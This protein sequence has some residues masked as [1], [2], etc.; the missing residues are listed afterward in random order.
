MKQPTIALAMIVKGAKD[1]AEHLAN[2]LD[3]I[4]SSVDAIYL[5][6]NT[7]KGV[8]IAPEI[9]AVA[10]KYKTTY[11][12]T[13]WKGN[14]VEARNFIFDKVDKKYGFLMWLDADDTVDKPDEIR[15]VIAILAKTQQGVYIRYDYDHDEFGNTTVSHMVARI[16]RNNGSYTWQSSIADGGVAVHETLVEV[17]PRP[18]AICEDFKVIHHADSDRRTQSLIRNIGLLEGM[19][20]RQ[21]KSG[22]VDPRTLFYLATHYYDAGNYSQAKDLLQNYMLLSGWAEERC[23]ALIYL[24]KIME[25]EGKT[26]QA[27]HAYLLAIG[28]Y[29]NSPRP[30]IE[31]SAID[32]KR[33]RFEESA[34]WI[35][36]C[37]ALPPPSTT[38][39]Q[40]PMESTFKAYMLA[41]QAYV[42]I[43]GKKLDDA[44]KYVLK[45]LDLRPL[46]DEAQQSRD[47]IESMIAQ[48]EDIRAAMR[49]VRKFEENDTKK[50]LPFLDTLPA[51]VQDNPLILTTRHRYT[52]PKVWGDKTIALYVGQGPLGVW[53]PWSL[54]EGIGGSEEAVIRLSRELALLGWNVT[55]Y[56]TPGERWGTDVHYESA[57]IW[58]YIDSSIAEKPQLE[59]E[60][61]SK[62]PAVQWKQYYEFNPRDEYNVL[63][64]WRNPAFFDAEI[65]AKK[66][67][68]WLH[69]VM[70]KEE[71]LPERLERI[72]KVIFVGQYHADL[73][74]GIIPEEKWFVSGNGIEPKD[75]IEA[76]GKFKRVPHRMV[77]MSSH[78]RGLKIL[79]DNWSEIKKAVPDATL[80]IYYGWQSFDALTKDNPERTEW[81]RQIVD[82]I[83]SLDGV[84]DH[85]RIS[86][87]Q[88][89]EEINKAEIFAYP[90]I[91][92]EVYCIS[93]VKAMAGGAF[94]V[95][96]D[97]GEL[98]NYAKYG[99][100]QVHYEY[101]KVKD[102][103]KA[104]TKELITAL[105]SD[106][107]NLDVQS[108]RDT[109][110][111]Q[112]TAKQWDK[113]ME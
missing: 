51:D 27:H 113:E 4:S 107:T 79:L 15:K 6:I 49:I 92:P 14:F 98:A 110:S 59:H 54:E 38:M 68:L 1:E 66:S 76:D 42:N 50:V 62:M 23:E 31:L 97:Y 104:Y 84:T 53:G 33:R 74:K 67:Y 83:N 18:K 45:A 8:K 28:E 25:M 11:F 10:K 100:K 112:N 30:Y 91:F 13:E 89:V 99:G 96:S 106:S 80:D 29:Q 72:D 47:I 9:I 24:G 40:R 71:F 3:N 44:Q 46:D 12:E 109:F 37:L 86:Q 19:Y 70:E 61:S 57:N 17:I 88:I 55:V 60:D 16:V 93:Q 34:S 108:V 43:G 103:A 48:R 20:K 39:V 41:A 73:Y 90:C 7:P 111:W 65:K 81:K 105:Q 77:Y 21:Q 5:N 101:G 78:N 94:P 87:F 95:T 2:C 63:V 52:E 35:E 22:E 36:K 32:F 64:S 82:Q 58:N 69:D 26:D 75:F 56:A 102:F 85:G